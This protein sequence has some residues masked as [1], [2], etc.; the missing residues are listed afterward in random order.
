MA[1]EIFRLVDL[2]AVGPVLGVVAVIAG[3]DDEDVA[4]FDAQARVVF[5]ALEMLR[6]IQVVI[7]YSHSLEVDHA[8][9]TDE[10][11]EPQIPYELATRKEMGR[12]IQ[13]RADVQGHRDLLPAG[14]VKRQTL[15]PADRRPRIAG[16]GRRVQREV[17]RE[18]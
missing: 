2:R 6:P 10:K 11:V 17:L 13:V 9:R 14:L 3:V 8:G 7:P 16:E 1:N 18:V 12:G 15:D 5:P 4:A